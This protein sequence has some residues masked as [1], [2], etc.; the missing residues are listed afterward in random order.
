[1]ENKEKIYICTIILLLCLSAWLWNPSQTL[2]EKLLNKGA[3]VV[4]AP[5]ISKLTKSNVYDLINNEKVKPCSQIQDKKSIQ[6]PSKNECGVKIIEED[7]NIVLITKTGERII[8]DEVLHHKIIR[9]KKNGSQPKKSVFQLIQ[10]ISTAHAAES[11]VC[12]SD[13]NG[14]QHDLCWPE[15]V[16][17]EWCLTNSHPICNLV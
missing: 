17:R 7:G 14:V 16:V 2:N 15:S 4:F 8:P 12:L 11:E 6:T 1:M 10:P 3:A 9:Y 5:N 13:L